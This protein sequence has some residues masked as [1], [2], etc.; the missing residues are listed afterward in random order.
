MAD[1][2]FR[3]KSIQRVSSPEQLNDYIRATNPGVWITLIA[4]VVLLVGFVVWGAA[5]TLETQVEAVAV[6]DAGTV[7]CYVREAQIADVAPG[8]TVHIGGAEYTVASIS[9]EPVAVDDSFSAYTLRVGGLTPGEWVYE[10][11]LSGSLPDGV[12]ET[13]VVTDKVSPIYFLFN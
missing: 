2:I 1:T 4:A 5:G 6:S 12:Y 3:E 8:D 11:A 7:T 9:A 10:V 13:S